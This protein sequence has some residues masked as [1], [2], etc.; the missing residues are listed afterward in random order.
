MKTRLFLLSSVLLSNPAFARD[1]DAAA[2]NMGNKIT[3]VFLTSTVLAA[4][5]VGF[6]YYFGKPGE[7]RMHAWNITEGIVIV[8]AIPAILALA[9][10]V[11]G[12]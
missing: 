5:F 9:Q 10:R 4:S 6:K 8:L 2:R 1:L 12:R 11:L 7:G 3:G